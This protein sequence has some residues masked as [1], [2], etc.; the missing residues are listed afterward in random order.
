ML[1]HSQV[2]TIVGIPFA[3]LKVNFCRD[4]ARIH[5]FIIIVIVVVVIVVIDFIY[6]LNFTRS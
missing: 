6:K 1:L 5:I 2:L 3:V 4:L